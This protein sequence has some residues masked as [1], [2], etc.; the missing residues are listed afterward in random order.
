LAGLSLPARGN[1]K[2]AQQNAE[3][4]LGTDDDIKPA[5]FMKAIG[6]TPMVKEDQDS[7]TQVYRWS[8]GLRTYELKIKFDAPWSDQPG[9]YA[10]T[11]GVAATAKLRFS[12]GSLDGYKLANEV[13]GS[14]YTKLAVLPE[15]GNPLEQSGGGPGSGGP[16]GGIGGD[17]G[18]PGRGFEKGSAG[19]GGNRPGGGRQGGGFGRSSGP[20]EE[21]NLSDDQKT[22]WTTTSSKLRDTMREIFTSGVP[23]EEMGAKM[24]ELRD[25][26]QEDL[27]TFLTEEQLAKYEEVRSQRPQGGRGG[28]GFGG[29]DRKGG[30]SGRSSGPPETLKLTDDQKTKWAAA[31]TKQRD[32]MREIFTSGIPR[33]E[34]GAKMTELREAFQANVKAFLTP[35]QQEKYKEIESQRPQRGSGG[36]GKQGGEG[37]GKR[38]SGPGKGGLGKGN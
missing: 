4:I 15:V 10:P 3:A 32:N 35:E 23:R 1:W 38:P 18:G 21:L 33:E 26:F 12:A 37:S 29:G 16:G 8:G 34:M 7:L 2:E 30:G 9:A 22:K 24:S 19:K 14:T 25:A 31:S 36:R 27:K 6:Q 13:T 5:A 20:P 11:E 28:G 17:S